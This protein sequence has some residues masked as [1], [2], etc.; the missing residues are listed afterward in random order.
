MSEA[1]P[2]PAARRGKPI[3][4]RLASAT[5][6][7]DVRR[8]IWLLT[9]VG[10][11]AAIALW[12]SPPIAVDPNGEVV[13]LGREAQWALA[14]FALAATWWVF[15]VVPIGVTAIA[16]G[17]AQA[18]FLIREPRVAWTDY[19]DPSVWF[20]FGSIVIGLVFTRTGLTRR[21]A[22]GM[23]MAVGEKT[24][25]IYLGAFLMTA[26]LTLVMAHT[27]VAAA[28]F[29]V[30]MAIHHLYGSGDE[31]TRFGAG[32]FVGMAFTAGAGSVISVG[33]MAYLE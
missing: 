11:F 24:R 16:I 6:A 19:F 25:N 29:P 7:R 17:V 31:K 5:A 23:L 4:V 8:W 14:L 26:G 30:L 3:L 28:L 12:P 33:S 20:I 21:L 22:Y 27:A 1:G 15:E 9:G 18:L 2:T 10:L 32:L 13:A